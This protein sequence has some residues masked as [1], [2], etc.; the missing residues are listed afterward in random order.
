MKKTSHELSALEQP[1]NEKEI[2][3]SFDRTNIFSPHSQDF[4]TKTMPKKIMLQKCTTQV[5]PTNMYVQIGEYY[6]FFLC[7]A[8]Q[9]KMNYPPTEIAQNK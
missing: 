4:F 2:H 5:V 8:Q 1:K 9:N 3:N 7:Q 6:I